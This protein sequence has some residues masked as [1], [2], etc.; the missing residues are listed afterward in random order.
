MLYI[1]NINGNQLQKNNLNGQ[2]KQSLTINVSSFE[3]EIYLYALVINGKK[4][5]T[6]RMI[7]TKQVNNINSTKGEHFDLNSNI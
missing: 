1:Y 3:P 2:G 6:K 4:V 5:D 7:L